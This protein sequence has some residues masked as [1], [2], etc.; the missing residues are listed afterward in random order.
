MIAD[1]MSRTK[2]PLS[3]WMLVRKSFLWI[4]D[5]GLIPEVDLFTKKGE[6]AISCVCASSEGHHDV[7]G[8]HCFDSMKPL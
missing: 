3:E 1:G 4:L 8:G 5:Q 2:P 7:C 6:L